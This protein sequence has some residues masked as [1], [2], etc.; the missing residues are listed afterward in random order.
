MY[1]AC[2]PSRSAI[3]HHRAGLCKLG[4]LR[5]KQVSPASASVDNI[6]AS[7]GSS[8]SLIEESKGGSGSSLGS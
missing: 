8:G 7:F 6:G 3:F 5:T 1:E 2:S 4:G